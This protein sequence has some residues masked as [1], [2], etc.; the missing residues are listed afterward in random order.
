M[1]YMDRVFA[2]KSRIVLAPKKGKRLWGK[3]LTVFVIIA[4][5]PRKAAFV[6]VKFSQTPLQTV[7]SLTPLFS[8]SLSF[9]LS[10]RQ[11]SATTL[12]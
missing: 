10:W 12:E 2:D 3:Q 9:S 11:Y 1:H 6:I 4:I 8:D 7:V 5:T